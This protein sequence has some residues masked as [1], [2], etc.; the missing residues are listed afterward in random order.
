MCILLVSLFNLSLILGL[1]HNIALLLATSLL[2]DIFWT[3]NLG[4]L[5][6]REKIITGL[7]LGGI[8]I[9]LMLTPWVLIPGLVFDT[10]SILLGIGGLFFGPLPTI[11]A[12]VITGGY[13]LFMG[14]DGQLMGIAVIISSAGIGLLWRYFRPDWEQRNRLAELYL[15]GLIIHLAML[16]CTLLL[17][18]ASVEATLKTIAAPVLV[19]YPLGTLLFGLL[20]YNRS[21]HWQIKKELFQSEEKFRQMFKNSAA[22]MLLV[23][24]ESGLIL[25]ANFAAAKFY[26]YP[27]EELT[28][29]HIDEINNLPADEAIEV[30][31]KVLSLEQIVFEVQHH[32]ANGE[33]RPVEIHSSPISFQG[34]TVLFSIIHDISVRKQAQAALLEAKERAEESDKLKSAFLATMSHELRTPLNAIIGFSSVMETENDLA[35][36]KQYAAIINN[37]GNHLLSIIESIFDVALLQSGEYKINKTSFHID[38]L[39]RSLIDYANVEKIKRDKDH[40]DVKAVF[41]VEGNLPMINTDRGKLMQLMTN[42]LNNAIK[43]THQGNIEFGVTINAT[44][45]TFF[46]SDTGIGIPADKVAV[47]FEKFRQGDDNYTRL[48]GGVG[49]GLAICKEI[50]AL[51][52]AKIWVET[53]ENQGSTFYFQLPE[54]LVT[55]PHRRKETVIPVK[56]GDLS[57][58]TILIVDDMEENIFLL[59][60]LLSITKAT[61]LSAN[62]GA[63]AISIVEKTPVVDLI[64]MDLKMPGMDGLEATASILKIRPGIRIIAQT[65]HAV[66]EV[67][68]QVSASGCYGYISKP[69]RRNELYKGLIEL[70]GS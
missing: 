54:A 45:I 3:R 7:L 8:G 59:E 53:A 39:F 33:I 50:A 31:R 1:I 10:R 62:S 34:Q 55:E 27:I 14:G 9:V 16:C 56:P 46:V 66:K 23:D 4:D 67:R 68:E 64:Y 65:A 5:K 25:D 13:R 37:S 47:V 43:Y 51:L 2:I 49:L 21:Q 38:E 30:R 36:M 24:P 19:I 58:K 6:L 40:L 22:I 11:I 26:G 61:I 69:I 20:M 41:P 18:D 60:K 52:G 17:P 42:L 15:L 44:D 29:K 63:A 12:I 28:Q 35:E 57:G 32:L 70:F 48:H